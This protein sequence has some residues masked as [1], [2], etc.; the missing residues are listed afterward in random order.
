VYKFHTT[1]TGEAD[2]CQF[3]K[4]NGVCQSCHG[5]GVIADERAPLAAAA[6]AGGVRSHSS[7]RRGWLERLLKNRT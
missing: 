6:T 3:C 2:K 7:T 4:G 5:K 1:L